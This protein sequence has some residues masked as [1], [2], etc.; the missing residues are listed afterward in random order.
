MN[1]ELDTMPDAALNELF[2][3]EVAGWRGGFVLWGNPS[4]GGIPYG[5]DAVG[6]WSPLPEFAVS[7]DAVLPWL[8]KAAIWSNESVSFDDTAQR[9]YCRVTL[10][11]RGGAIGDVGC[12][13]RASTFAR[14]AV[15]A[16]ICAKR[17]EWRTT[18]LDSV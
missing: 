13:A 4:G 1:A 9:H 12:V 16:L 10:Q 3:V 15:I 11:R 18:G 7:A 14:A 17:A 5:N 6:C 8:E 2:A